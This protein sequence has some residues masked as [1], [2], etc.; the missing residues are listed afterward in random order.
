M[1]KNSVANVKTMPLSRVEELLQKMIKV[2]PVLVLGDI[3]IDKYTFGEVVRISPEAPVPVVEVQKEWKKL[4]L[5]ANVTDNLQAL[6]VKTTLCGVVGEDHNASLLFEMLDHFHISSLGILKTS[7]RMTTFKERVTTSAQQ[8]CRI[9][10]ETRLPLED[11]MVSKLLEKI[12]GMA[13]LHSA[14]IIEDYAKGLVTEKMAQEAISI[15]K[16]MGKLVVIDPSRGTPASYYKGASLLKPNLPEAK[17]LCESLG[18]RHLTDPKEMSQILL[19]KLKLDAVVLTL[20][21]Q[22]ML[23]IDRQEFAQSTQIATQARDVFDV[24]GAGDTVV[25]LLTTSLLAGANLWEASWMANLAAGIVVGKKGTAT[26]DAAE[27]VRFYKQITS[28]I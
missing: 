19:D 27:M 20:G 11:A 12:E 22:G 10:Y 5:A 4:G 25:S 23:I 26:T 3:G 8:I 17:L 18:Y 6:G 1:S 13:T 16:D 28:I 21:A 7:K 2:P 14:L 9:D 24:S 15:F